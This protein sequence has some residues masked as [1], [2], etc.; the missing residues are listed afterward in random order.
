MKT[1]KEYM[2]EQ[3]VVDKHVKRLEV[4]SNSLTQYKHRWNENPSKRLSGWVDEYNQIK[5]DH[6]DSFLAFSKKHGYHP[7]HNAYDIL[8]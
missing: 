8:A 3:L 6:R 5:D 2:T 4:L 7:S 1:F